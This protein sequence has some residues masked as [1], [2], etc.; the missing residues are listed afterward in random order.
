MFKELSFNFEKPTPVNEQV[1]FENT[2]V[3]ITETSEDGIITNTNEAFAKASGYNPF[4]LIGKSHSIVRHPDMPKIIY[5]ILWDTITNG[6]TFVGIIKNISKSGKYFWAATEIDIKADNFGNKRFVAKRKAILH[7][8]V[9]ETVEPLYET[10]VK[11]EKVG[12][13]ELS[14][15]YFKNYLAKFGKDYL[16]FVLDVLGDNE[17][18]KA[19]YI[20]Q[21]ESNQVTKQEEKEIPSDEIFKSSDDGTKKRKNFF[22]KLF[23]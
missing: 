13:V 1:I 20:Q 11:L 22:Q 3:L 17:S 5:K 16:D 14:N 4:E 9:A 10:L 12:G 15:R 23:S 21:D 8:V 2:D 6:D 7:G 18:L 19:T